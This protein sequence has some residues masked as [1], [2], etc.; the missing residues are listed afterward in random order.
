MADHDAL[1]WAEVEELGALLD[2]LR[3]EE[4]DAPS[5]CEGWRVRDVYGHMGFGH[6]TPFVGLLGPMVR[7]K[8]NIPKASFDLSKAFAS[9]R[10]PAELR[11]FWR[12][13]MVAKHPKKGIAKTIKSVDGFLD[14][15]IH[16]QDIRR[17]LGRPR[18]IAPDHLRAV[19]DVL[20]KVHSP[21]FSTRTPI[22]GLRL[23]ATDLPWTLG[24]GPAVR[25]PGEA[26]V[27]AAAGRSVALA[28][29]EGD[30]VDTLRSRTSGG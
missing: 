17:P 22:E 27:M 11:A 25:G 29:L 30:G 6:T 15:F 13:E 21:M 20:P 19:L 2:D 5:L 23:E 7:Y 1:M 4:L 8:G 10:S 24:D 3:D 9:E 28:E 12:D 18:Q 14:H 16:Q 26:L